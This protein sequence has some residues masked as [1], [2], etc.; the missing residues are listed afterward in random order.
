[1]YG[2]LESRLQLILDA[3]PGIQNVSTDR[4]FFFQKGRDY[5]DADHVQMFTKFE[6]KKSEIYDSE[7]GS[8]PR[9]HVLSMG[10][11]IE[12]KTDQQGL[13]TY[14]KSRICM[15]VAIG[16]MCGGMAFFL[17]FVVHEVVAARRKLM[18]SLL[19]DGQLAASFATQVGLCLLLGMVSG[20]VVLLVQPGAAGSGVPEIIAFLN[21]VHIKD[22]TGIKTFFVKFVSCAAAVSAGL[23][24]GME[25]PIIHLG[26]TGHHYNH[27]N[28]TK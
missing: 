22:N 14:T 17:D 20:L 21:R 26:L 24:V 7:E 6:K 28:S 25:G 16:L 11:D 8:M 15:F 23:P 27:D 3:N 2:R 13:L 18:L 12:G 5:T 19:S 10:S 4:T 1:V 9:S